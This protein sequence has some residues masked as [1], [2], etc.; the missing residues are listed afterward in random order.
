MKRLAAIVFL[1]ID[2]SFFY[3]EALMLPIMPMLPL[4]DPNY[5]SDA[6]EMS[7]MLELEMCMILFYSRIWGSFFRERY[8]A[9]EFWLSYSEI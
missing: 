2:Y 5:F 3:N 9:S 8:C 7:T 4:G 1:S 6:F